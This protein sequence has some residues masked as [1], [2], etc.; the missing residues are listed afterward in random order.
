MRH[1]YVL[2]FLVLAALNAKADTAQQVFS[3]YQHSLLQIQVVEK[4][5]QHK[6]EYGSGFYVAPDL[7][8]TNYHVI[9]SLIESPEDYQLMAKIGE[10]GL[11]ALEVLSLDVVN[12]LALLRTPIRTERYFTLADVL[13]DQGRIVFS[14]G[15]P[16]DL[17]MV[18]VPGTYNGFIEN[19]YYPRLHLT[20]SINSGMSGG[21]SL[22]EEGQVIGVNV[23]TGGNQLGFVV[24]LDR[25]T[26]LIESMPA[27][28]P[29]PA[30]LKR[31]INAQLLQNQ[32]VMLAPILEDDWSMKALGNGRVPESIAPH[33]SCW[34]L[35]N[36]P[37]TQYELR[38]S[39]AF[40]RQSEE[41]FISEQFATGKI[42]MQF[43]WIDGSQLPLIKFNH[44]YQARIQGA[45]A[46]NRARERDV[47]KFKCLSDIVD[48]N[49]Q[50]SRLVYCIRNYKNYPDLYDA[51][52]L[53][54]TVPEKQQ[55]FISRFTLAGV[56]KDNAQ[57]F[58]RKFMGAVVW[59]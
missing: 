49:G 48:L 34:G 37:Q 20:G 45:T 3:Q 42:Q 31:Q 47:S 12:D 56:S 40:C 57:I 36:Q 52:Y 17:G 44:H 28:Q 14:L 55:G 19:S 25:I 54:A 39:T 22:N 21:P 5:T 27:A 43:Q 41:I 53:A 26:A 8:V 59:E 11:Q 35:A 23:A 2:L 15:N 16:H 4:Q 18:V 13:P 58:L 33:I 9:S 10:E 29:D 24:P 6:S 38:S 30:Q 32:Q 1:R 51:V 46:N 7:V 50:A